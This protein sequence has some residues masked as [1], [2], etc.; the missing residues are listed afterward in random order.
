[1]ELNQVWYEERESACVELILLTTLKDACF[2]FAQELAIAFFR[3]LSNEVGDLSIED[4]L[5]RRVLAL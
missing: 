4:G 1:M 5:F 2:E 3:I